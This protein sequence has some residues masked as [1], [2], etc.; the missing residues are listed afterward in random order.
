VITQGII[1]G[2]IHND[3]TVHNGGS[4]SLDPIDKD[5]QSTEF[6]AA[7]IVRGHI[8]LYLASSSDVC[9]EGETIKNN[10]RFRI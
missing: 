3:T 6:I 1:G 2:A 10:I 4:A 7:K 5:I 9:T 8:R